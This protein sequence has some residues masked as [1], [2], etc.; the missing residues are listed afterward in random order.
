MAGFLPK[1]LVEVTTPQANDVF[2]IEVDGESEVKKVKFSNIIGGQTL[3][4]LSLSANNLQYTDELGLITNLDLSLYL[5]DTNLAYIQSGV[6]DGGTGIATFTRSDSTTFTL[7]LSDLLSE[8]SHADVVVDGD[9]PTAGVM[10]TDGSGIYSIKVIGVD[11]QAYDVNI[12]SDVDYSSTK[13]TINAGGLTASRPV[14]PILYQNYFDT[15]LGKP[16]WFD[17]TN[18]VDSTGATV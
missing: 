13:A 7:D 18:W 12:V 9:F 2:I 15:T 3:T 17:G 16:V 14:S 10:A 4:S 8:T 6:L 5:D 1:D 11:I